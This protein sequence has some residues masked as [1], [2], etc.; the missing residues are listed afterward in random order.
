MLP[1][2]VHVL[3]VPPAAVLRSA[4]HSSFPVPR[5]G[6]PAQL[7]CLP[8][9]CCRRRSP[10]ATVCVT[11]AAM[12]ATPW[13]IWRSLR[14]WERRGLTVTAR[15]ARTLS[16]ARRA[17]RMRSRSR[18]LHSCGSSAVSV[19]LPARQVRASVVCVAIFSTSRA[20]T[21]MPRPRSCCTSASRGCSTPPP[22]SACRARSL[23]AGW[24]PPT[25]RSGQTSHCVFRVVVSAIWRRAAAHQPA[26]PAAGWRWPWRSRPRLPAVPGR[27]QAALDACPSPAC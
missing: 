1:V 2:L 21:W 4:G 17:R 7:L 22:W 25:T 15:S 19:R 24:S 14:R 12:W 26:R 20:L 5:A 27:V 10:S 23:P 18:P 13:V 11:T 6:P 8:R 3:V 9:R 16:R